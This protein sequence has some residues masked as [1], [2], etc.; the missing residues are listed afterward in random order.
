MPPKKRKAANARGAHALP[1]PIPE[2]EVL[3]DNLKHKWKVGSPIGSGGF[4][5]I[6]LGQSIMKLEF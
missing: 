2:G 4:G 3:T 6:Y 1:P 5:L